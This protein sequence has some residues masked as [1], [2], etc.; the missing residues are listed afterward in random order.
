M[1]YCLCYAD[2][3]LQKVNDHC[4]QLFAMKLPD[5]I[6]KCVDSH[7]DTFSELGGEKKRGTPFFFSMVL[8]SAA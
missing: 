2:Q 3:M 7:L 5:A 4:R 1:Q 6:P 8:K